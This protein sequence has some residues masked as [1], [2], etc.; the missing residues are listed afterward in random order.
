MKS[1]LINQFSLT[2]IQNFTEDQ[3]TDTLAFLRYILK[4]SESESEKKEINTYMEQINE[5]CNQLK[6]QKAA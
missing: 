5:R 1:F 2:Q 3:C 6:M 4:R